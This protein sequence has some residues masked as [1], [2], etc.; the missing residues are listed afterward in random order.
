MYVPRPT[1]CQSKPRPYYTQAR[2]SRVALVHQHRLCVCLCRKPHTHVNFIAEF[3]DYAGARYF[4]CC[5]YGTIHTKPT[6]KG[7]PSLI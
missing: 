3:G 1:T 4:F 6:Q 7:L 5:S 2:I